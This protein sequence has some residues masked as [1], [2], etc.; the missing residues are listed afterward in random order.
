TATEERQKSVSFT[1]PYFSDAQVLLA[2]MPAGAMPAKASSSNTVANRAVTLEQLDG[3]RIGV[4]S[5]SAGD[6]AARKR[7][8][9]ASI[10]DM[11]A[12]ADAALAVKTSKADAFVY[13]KSVLLNLAAKNPELVILDEPVAKLEVAAVLSKNN[14]ALLSSINKV[15]EEMKA[16]GTLQHLRH[17]WIES[18]QRNDAQQMPRTKNANGVLKVGTNA[19]IEPFSFMSNGKIIGLDI[20]LAYLLGERLGKRVEIV[21]MPFESLIPALQAGK[22]DF[23]LS[24]FNVTEER[25]KLINFSLPY[26]DNDISALVRRTPA[27]AAQ[28]AAQDSGGNSGGVKLSTP[29]DLKDKRIGVL[30]GS[31]QDRYVMRTFPNATVLQYKSPSDLVLA[32]KSGKVDAGLYTTETL[33][34]MFRS[35]SEMGLV[36]DS[37]YPV[38]IAMG[39]KKGNNAL[40]EKFNDFLRQIKSNGVYGDMV[41]RWVKKG[42]TA[43]PVIANPKP[44]GVLIVGTVSDKGLPFAAMQNNTLIGFDT[45]LCYRFAAFL[46]KE[47][48]FADMEFGSLIAAVSTNKIDMVA[49]TLMIT[50]ERKQQVDFSDAYYEMGS[51]AFAMKKT[52]VVTGAPT[53]TKTATPSFMSG[54]IDSFNNNI[55]KE[56]RYLL[57][58]DGLKVTVIVAVLSSVFG[59]L[60]GALVCFM[61]MSKKAILNVPAKAYISVLRGTPVLVL[62]MLIFYVAF[63]SVDIDPVLVAVI[64]FGMN[65]AAYAAE[66]FRSGIEG[67]DKGQTEAGIAM[68]F[69]KVNTFRYIVLPQAVRQFLP[70]YKGEFISLVKMTSIVGYI[71]V[72]DLTKASDIIRS[73]TFDA[74]FPLIMV[75]ILYFVISWFLTQ[76][77]EYLERATDPKRKRKKAGKA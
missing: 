42:A 14:A 63:A 17:K 22:I 48:R 13:D 67:V 21:N 2:K 55:I 39:F 60:L 28:P 27:V 62:L 32:V 36:G 19:T 40:R 20:E 59:T 16:A 8:P 49:S 57:I 9:K 18:K 24:N 34:E 53:E 15:L 38:P 26:I 46:G 1:Q 73:R 43:M 12:A 56:Q 76:S 44:K 4:L 29:A 37:L 61:R 77:L 33:Q 41:D 74:F 65:F 47:V 10:L 23:A 64:A 31:E 68:G 70:V 6:L 69:T 66:I 7:F 35:D 51:S 52:I 25:K 11:N 72:Q 30:L 58:L 75:A 5:G 71:A 3:Q 50:E 54:V 45:E